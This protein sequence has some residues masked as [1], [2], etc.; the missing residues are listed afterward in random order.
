[1]KLSNRVPQGTKPRTP[2]PALAVKSAGQPEASD[3]SACQRKYQIIQVKP[4]RSNAK[5]PKPTASHSSPK[6][7]PPQLSPHWGPH[8]RRRSGHRQV[9]GGRHGSKVLAPT[10]WP[11]RLLRHGALEHRGAAALAAL[12]ASCGRWAKSLGQLTA[13]SCTEAAWRTCHVVS[14][15]DTRFTRI[16]DALK[17]L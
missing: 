4:W 5:D 10:V 6:K 8:R 12:A 9:T 15:N 14:I 3:K 16:L 11:W 17:E 7:Q 2:T 1:M 13:N